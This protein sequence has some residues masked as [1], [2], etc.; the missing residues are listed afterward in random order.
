MIAETVYIG[1]GSNLGDPLAQLRRA[2][3]ALALLPG[4]ELLA[5]SRICR[6]PPMGPKDQPDYLNG[7]VALRTDLPPLELLGALQEIERRQGRVRG[8]VR[9]GPRTIDL[10]LLLYGRRVL[11]LPELTVPHPEMPSRPFVL[12][13]LA[14]M[15]GEAFMLP[16]FGKVGELLERCPKGEL[17]WLKTGW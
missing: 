1:L 9:W 5:A 6:T 4:T 10:D 7:V 2:R 14:E 3:E 8:P 12:Y 17:L 16:R 13:P 15:V 11:N